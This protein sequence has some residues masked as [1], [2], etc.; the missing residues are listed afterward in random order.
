MFSKKVKVVFLIGELGKGGSERQLYLI[1]KNLDLQKIVPIIVVFNESPGTV[2]CS[3]LRSLGIQV[4][5]IPPEKKGILGRVFL[6]L[7]LFRQVKPDI[8]HS[9][10]IH[11]NPYAGFVGFLSG[12]H[13]RFGS[14]RAS[15][16]HKNFKELPSFYQYLS[17]Y[18]VQRLFVNARSTTHELLARNYP[19]ER[20]VFLNNCVE[21]QQKNPK[22]DVDHFFLK[23]INDQNI[24]IASVGNLR[25][26]KN[27]HIFIEGLAAINPDYPGL[28]GLIIGQSFPDEI[29]YLR[30]LNELIKLKGLDDKVFIVGFQDNAPELM[31]SFSILC[32]LSSQEATPNVLL[33][34]MA[35]G[36]PVIA[37]RV[38]GIVD[39]ITDG[40]NGFL[41]NPEDVHDF[42][43]AL[44]KLLQDPQLAQR[45][46]EVGRRKMALEYSCQAISNQLVEFYES[47]FRR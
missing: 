29:D 30:Y 18:L 37:T 14:M 26:N 9:W 22:F 8:V 39:V 21:I 16:K 10:S 3:E 38:G 41:V 4:Y 23:G 43:M 27:F 17:L 2:Y 28:V 45:M 7:K 6:L 42:T 36:R 40:E 11:D 20:I 13:L 1:V 15:L 24:I 25:R 34:A 31:A 12:V 46:G 44:R 19:S 32:L 35:A 5:E 47:F 33:E